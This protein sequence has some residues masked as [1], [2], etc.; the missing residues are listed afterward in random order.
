MKK[1]SIQQEDKF[2]DS[3]LRPESWDNYIGQE[4]IK[5]SLKIILGA[6][7]KR[8]EPS[9]HLL[10]YGQPGLGKT[11]L[12]ALV[13]KEM[14]V[15]LKTISGPT[16]TKSGDLAAILTN[17]EKNEILFIDEAHRISR[18]IEELFYSAIDCGK[19]NLTV[20]K[21]PSARIISL[22]LPPFTL[23]AA[24][25]RVNLISSPLRSRFG[26]IFRFDYYEPEDIEEIIKRSAALLEVNISKEAILIIAKASR[27]VPRLANRLLKRAR[28]VAQMSSPLTRK[29]EVD[30][31]IFIDG[32]IVKETFGM[33]EIDELGL[34]T[35]DRRLLE[36][37]IKKFNN[38]PVGINTLVASLGEEKEAIEEIY[39]PYL[40]KI[41]F[42]QRTP[43]GRIATPEAREWLG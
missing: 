7:R 31:L 33:L 29:G 5:K 32:N 9:D 28:D 21:G 8:K 36:I 3:L 4:K 43:R 6:A 34:E 15:D 24:T 1:K 41:G 14:R 2:L 22:D 17:L 35:Y 26:A 25:T 11:T 19:I 30:N 10:F 18:P 16:L 37:I 40:L 12:A 13:A 39:E 42:L 38:R 23:I 20:G 27:C